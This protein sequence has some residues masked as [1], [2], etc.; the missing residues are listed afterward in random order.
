MKGK[1]KSYPSTKR[2]T[3]THV[4]HLES[5]R[6]IVRHMAKEWKTMRGVLNAAERLAVWTGERHDDEGVIH[7]SFVITDEMGQ[8]KTVRCSAISEL[9]NC[10]HPMG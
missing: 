9:P 7:N 2:Y 1:R 5:G 6:Q 10:R 8:F 3:I 4:I